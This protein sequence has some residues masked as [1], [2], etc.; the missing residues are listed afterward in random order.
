MYRLPGEH[1]GTC[2]KRTALQQLCPAVAVL[3]SRHLR[4]A[5]VRRAQAAAQQTCPGCH[6][7]AGTGSGL[8]VWRRPVRDAH[9]RSCGSKAQHGTLQHADAAALSLLPQPARQARVHVRT[10]HSAITSSFVCAN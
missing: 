1:Y 7:C 4:H 10:H 2:R 8:A 3:R 9:R 5:D 6:S